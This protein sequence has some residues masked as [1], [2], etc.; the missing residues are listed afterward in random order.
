MRVLGPIILISALSVPHVGELLTLS[1]AVAP[2]LVGHDHPR[3][4][5]QTLQ[6]PA[7]E[8]LCDTGIVPVLNKNVEHNTILIDGRQR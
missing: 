1:D 3:D 5:L 2:Q 8:A 4:T 7:E 6:K